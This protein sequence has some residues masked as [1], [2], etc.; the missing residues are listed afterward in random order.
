MTRVRLP[1]MTRNRKILAAAVIAVAAAVGITLALNG[2]AGS[3]NQGEVAVFSRVQART[4][5]NT[6]TLTGTLAR[7][8]IRNITSATQGIISSVTSADDSTTQ[9][10][11]TMFAING[12]DAI[13]EQGTV[14]FFRRW[15]PAT[16]ATTCCS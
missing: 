5:Q 8:S 9:A 3:T 15:R 13:A 11:Q 12:R 1:K 14:P 2:S 16:R 10:G 6:V 7:K 4:L